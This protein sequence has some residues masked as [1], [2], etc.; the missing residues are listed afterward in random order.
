MG[1][2]EL[3]PIPGRTWARTSHPDRLPATYTRLHGTRQWLAFF[4]T[5]QDKLW[6]YFSHRKRWQQVLRA[7][8]WM[9]SRYSVKERIYL[10][11]DNFSPHLRPEIRRWARHNNVTLV[12]TPTNASW[13]NHIEPQFT[14][15][16]DFVLANSNY[17][18]HIEMKTAFND[19]LKYRNSR[20][21]KHK[22]T[23]LER[24]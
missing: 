6:G 1:P 19:F 16:H 23:N 2:L 4:D 7:F 24:Y 3:R 15:L 5:R 17:T 11:L 13:L 10:I 21:S 9:R 8:Q 12:W 14:E 20:N 18:T 22:K